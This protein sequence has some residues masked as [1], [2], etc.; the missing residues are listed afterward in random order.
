VIVVAFGKFSYIKRTLCPSAARYV[1]S[2]HHSE[3]GTAFPTTSFP[4]KKI[5]TYSLFLYHTV[6]EEVSHRP[7]LCAS[8]WKLLA[9]ERAQEMEESLFAVRLASSSL[10]YSASTRIGDELNSTVPTLLKLQSAAISHIPHCK[11]NRHLTI[12]KQKLQEW[13]RVKYSFSEL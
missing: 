1:R 4:E 3:G 11:G 10:A 9:F 5:S 6:C 13:K 12:K 8:Q 7:K 2:G